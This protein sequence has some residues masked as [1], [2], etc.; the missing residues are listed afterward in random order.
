MAGAMRTLLAVW[1]VFLLA[2]VAHVSAGSSASSAGTILY[3]L[4]PQQ[5]AQLFSVETSAPFSRRDLRIANVVDAA[6]AHGGAA[7]YV[8]RRPPS[9]QTVELIRMRLDGTH[10][11]ILRARL[12]NSASFAVAPDDKS[13]ALLSP[14]GAILMVKLGVASEP[15]TLVSDTVAHWIA[16]SGDGR[17]L[18]YT[19]GSRT[20]AGHCWSGVADLCA[21]DLLTD[22]THTVGPL[23]P[24]VHANINQEDLSLSA[25]GRRIAFTTVAGPAAIAVMD[26][27]GR[28]FHRLVINRNAFSP[29]WSP[30][31]NSI[32][33]RVDLRGIVITD[34][35]HKTTRTIAIFTGADYPRLVGWNASR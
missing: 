5:Q 22:Q 24:H 35:Q 20:P 26:T 6:Y 2:V 1:V 11:Q 17:T 14:Q 23:P 30:N 25:D 8:M 33:Y 31:G 12:P 13:V 28:H 21:F 32:A 16:W 19:G 9:S 10:Q 27:D 7:I 29:A 3:I 18:Y 34:L 15:R 4:D